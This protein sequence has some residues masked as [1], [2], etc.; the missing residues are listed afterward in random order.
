MPE[1]NDLSSPGQF[2]PQIGG[3]VSLVALR[4]TA[5]VYQANASFR[6]AVTSKPLV[7]VYQMVSLAASLY[8]L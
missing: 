8:Y 2:S 5:Y 4:T 1:I 7:P 3:C 6:G